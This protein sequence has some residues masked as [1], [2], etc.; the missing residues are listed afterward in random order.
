MELAA[1]AL[2]LPPA[3][4]GWTEPKREVRMHSGINVLPATR[5]PFQEA[6]LSLSSSW[7]LHSSETTKRLERIREL[8]LR[9]VY[10]LD[11]VG[12]AHA[13][14]QLAHVDVPW[15]TARLAEAV[16]RIRELE[17]RGN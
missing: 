11:T 12:C 4:L 14:S 16:L 5:L 10:P 15:L 17:H 13:Q 1:A 6:E 3:F 9:A 2:G 8:Q 7:Q